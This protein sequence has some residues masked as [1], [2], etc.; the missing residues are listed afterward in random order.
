MPARRPPKVVGPD[1]LNSRNVETVWA[2]LAEWR[3]VGPLNEALA[4]IALTL[5]RSLDGGAGMAV[6][7]VS[8][9]LRATLAELEPRADDEPDDADRWLRE[10]QTD[11][12]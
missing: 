3:R 5:A 8:K 2:K 11:L 4:E 12:G 6:A 10:L 9:E 1:L 7:A